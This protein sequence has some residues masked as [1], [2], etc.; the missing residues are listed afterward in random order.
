MDYTYR[1][2]KRLHIIPAWYHKSYAHELTILPS[3]IPVVL[4]RSRSFGTGS[5]ATTRMCLTLLETCLKPG[6]RVLDLGCGSGI[7][8]I[9]AAK[10]G[11]GWVLAVDIDPEA[12]RA[13]GENAALNGISDKIELR[14]GS[15]QQ[16]AAGSQPLA[17]NIIIA[18]LFAYV[19][20]PLLDE[21][22]LAKTLA[23]NGLLILSGILAWQAES[24]AA[25]LG[26][27]GLTLIEQQ[28]SDNGWAALVARAEQ[29]GAAD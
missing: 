14:L 21:G 15:F 17:F 22:L 29:E 13:T 9:A 19:L 25:A 3:D 27:A 7:L 6:D 5:H 11:A 20:I 1:I 4:E 23:P 18:N 26:D 10:L 24:V 2:G 12:G 16:L 28:V 8:S